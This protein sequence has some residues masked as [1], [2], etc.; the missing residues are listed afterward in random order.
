VLA[1]TASA[2][3]RTSSSCRER[4]ATK[5]PAG[6]DAQQRRAIPVTYLTAYQMLCEMAA[7]GRAIAC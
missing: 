7:C 2:A 4:Q 1:L 5:R 6:L 3:T